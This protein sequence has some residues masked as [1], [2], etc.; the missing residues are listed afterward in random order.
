MTAM[1]DIEIVSWRA[2]NNVLRLQMNDEQV[3]ISL[4]G[5]MG[6]MLAFIFVSRTDLIEALETIK[7]GEELPA[8]RR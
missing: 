6:G 2:P 5:P 7:R 3:M 4:H 8:A 1:A